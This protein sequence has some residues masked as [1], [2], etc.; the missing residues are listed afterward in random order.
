MNL[1]NEEGPGEFARA[2]GPD[3]R[4]SARK[5]CATECSAPTDNQHVTAE[6]NV[7]ARRGDQSTLCCGRSIRNAT[8]VARADSRA[9]SP[10]PVVPPGTGNR[11]LL[12]FCALSDDEVTEFVRLHPE[13]FDALNSKLPESERRS[14]RA[15]IRTVTR[16]IDRAFGRDLRQFGDKALQAVQ[17][18]RRRARVPSVRRDRERRSQPNTGSNSGDDDGEGSGDPDDPTELH[19]D[20][21][22]EGAGQAV[23]E[24]AEGVALDRAEQAA[25]QVVPG[26]AEGPLAAA[27][28]G[29][30]RAIAWRAS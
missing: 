6:H 13:R 25:E 24:P 18:I 5:Q 30:D 15:A 11:A 12:A 23:L 16:A 10:S 8:E 28:Q 9:T 29:G 17:A 14:L 7:S 27:K 26:R 2:P 4:T 21:H 3:A 19:D 1:R 22:G 20:R